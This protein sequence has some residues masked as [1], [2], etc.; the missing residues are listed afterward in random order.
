MRHTAEPVE[1]LRGAPDVSGF[2]VSNGRL[3]RF[4]SLATL[5]EPNLP[6]HSGHRELFI[7]SV[8]DL[9][10]TYCTSALTEDQ[11]EDVIFRILCL[12]KLG[13]HSAI[14]GTKARLPVCCN[15]DI[16]GL[17]P[18]LPMDAH[19]PTPSASPSDPN[20]FMTDLEVSKCMKHVHKG[21][22]RKA[23][24][25]IRGGS[26]IAPLTEDVL[27]TL[28]EK[29]PEGTP[30]PFNNLPKGVA[31][32]I[33]LP[34]TV[35]LKGLIRKLSKETSPGI[36]GWS[37]KLIQLCFGEDN[38]SPFLHF[39]MKL[40]REMVAGTAPGR[41]F[42][43]TSRLTPLIQGSKIRPI[44]CG[45]LFYRLLMRFILKVCPVAPDALLAFQLGVGTP[46][47]VEPI[48]YQMHRIMRESD[49]IDHPLFYTI[50]FQNAFNSV[51]RVTIAEGV[52][53][54]ARHLF[55]LAEWAYG[56]PTPLVCRK[57]GSYEVISSSQGVRQGDP[58]GPLLF[59]LA[60]RPKLAILKEQLSQPTDIIMSYLDDVTVTSNIPDFD[61]KIRDI[62]SGADGLIIN[63][64]K[65]KIIDAQSILK[66][67]TGLS[68]LGSVIGNKVA[69]ER[70]LTEKILPV[71]SQLRRLG[72]LPSQYAL[73]LL[74]QCIHPEMKHL[75]R[76]M[77]LQDLLPLLNDF[78]EGIYQFLEHLRG[79][80]HTITI[81]PIARRIY[82]L[83]LSRGGCGIISYQELSEPARVAALEQSIQF[84][85]NR[86]ILRWPGEI[87]DLQSQKNQFGVVLDNATATFVQG[88]TPDQRLAFYDNGSKC[89]TAW[90]H[91][92]PYGN[93]RFLSNQQVAAALNIR[94]L[95]NDMHNRPICSRC[96]QSQSPQHHESCPAQRI[97]HQTRHNLIRDRLALFCKTNG[98]LAICE[99]PLSNVPNPPRADLLVSTV[100]DHMLRGQHYDLS[101]KLIKAR[102]TR[103]NSTASQPSEEGDIRKICYNQIEAALEKCAQDKNTHYR[104]LRCQDS[105]T[106]LVISS[107]G[108][109]HKDLH[110][111]L[112]DIQPNG[113][114]R[115]P[116]MVDLSLILIRARACT[117][118]IA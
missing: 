113:T 14:A 56:H 79:V 69:R 10:R 71:L 84:L 18:P 75:L 76:T 48:I 60:I 3:Q 49:D 23:A 95:Q 74:R 70:F 101:I 53:G 118:V 117:Y 89:G 80:G 45:E 47:G 2:S 12:P 115:H 67:R 31:P 44:A 43:C 99:P 96:Q 34:D 83:P 50:D 105:V 77:D 65:S 73:L 54:H 108:T 13:L 29:H 64:A 97:N 52:S 15:G 37:A 107:G 102:D 112:K 98:Q 55:R 21:Q 41:I 68:V 63:T 57:G 85:H 111:F 20:D 93:Y 11:K 91:A 27:S 78:D 8:H 1:P 24:Q 106:P 42:L 51:S 88:L 39:L 38:R 100:P 28:K 66:S 72:Q 62:F 4:L 61:V 17:F 5:P 104:N 35:I 16:N 6:G 25:I 90:L 103:V 110:L 26:S 7:R 58:L 81:D 30:D 46:G 86:K 40:S 9:C 19:S 109:L 92:I 116:L 33:T 82:S 22:L 114:F 32:S 94:T 87:P 36:S 59:S